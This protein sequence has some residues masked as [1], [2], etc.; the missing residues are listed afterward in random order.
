MIFDSP[1]DGRPGFVVGLAVIALST[2]IGCANTTA[3]NR[4]GS[5]PQQ[6]SRA[7]LYDPFP[8]NRMG[9][10]T[11]ELRPREFSQPLPEPEKAQLWSE[12]QRAR[13]MGL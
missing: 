12:R 10:S 11:P 5:M 4:P 13:V 2:S 3:W 6:Q 9:P 1:S 8:D 7:S